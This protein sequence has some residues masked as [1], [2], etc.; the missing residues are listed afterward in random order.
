[1]LGCSTINKH[2]VVK[3]AT[4]GKITVYSQGYKAKDELGIL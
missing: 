1:M 3:S 4:E 2:A